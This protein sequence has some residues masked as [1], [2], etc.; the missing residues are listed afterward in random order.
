VCYGVRCEAVK[1]CVEMCR[2]LQIPEIPTAF[3]GYRHAGAWV[4]VTSEALGRKGAA[5]LVSGAQPLRPALCCCTSNTGSSQTVKGLH[6][7]HGHTGH[8][9]LAPAAAAEAEQPDALA[10]AVAAE[11][12]SAPL[13][14]LKRL[15]TAV[16]K[17]RKTLR[18]HT[19]IGP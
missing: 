4:H 1:T 2:P 12:S 14:A 19:P 13:L 3:V 9:A 18:Q 5:R 11:D 8:N 7:G 16:S 15:A 6:T 17:V 10:A